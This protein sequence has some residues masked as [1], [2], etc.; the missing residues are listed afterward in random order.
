M[1]LITIIVILFAM[2]A[3]VYVFNAHAQQSTS[4]SQTSGGYMTLK[5]FGF[6]GVQKGQFNAPNGVAIDSSGNVYV[7]DSGNSRVPNLIAVITLLEHGEEWGLAT[8]NSEVQ[9][10]LQ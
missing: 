6:Q 10:V 2:N 1:S 7:L 4:T 8:V 3:S 5:S 9:L